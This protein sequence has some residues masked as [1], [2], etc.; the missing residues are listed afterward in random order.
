MKITVTKRKATRKEKII[1]SIE[2]VALVVAIVYLIV[3]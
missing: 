1:G 3:R 2:W